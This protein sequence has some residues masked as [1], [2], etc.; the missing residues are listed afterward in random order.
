MNCL[1]FSQDFAIVAQSLEETSYNVDAAINY[2]LQLMCIAEEQ[3]F[4]GDHGLVF[5]SGTDTFDDN[6][7][8]SDTAVPESIVCQ[9]AGTNSET[10][11][12]ERTSSPENNGD[13]TTQ[14]STTDKTQQIMN[15]DQS[16]R[17]SLATQESLHEFVENL[18]DSL[19][20][21]ECPKGRAQNNQGAR[22]KVTR[23]KKGHGQ[24]NLS[25]KKRKELAKQ[26]KKKRKMEERKENG[27]KPS[28]SSVVTTENNMSG[29]LPDL[30]A[31]VI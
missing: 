13:N 26:E 10:V 24:G 15:F 20:R 25:N 5:N 29:V 11:N 16:E 18:R 21:P 27:P 7:L 6:S 3:G 17:E 23:P 4:T 30:G 12:E 14:N 22:P 9:E 1:F 8:T 19:T 31:L 28:T 2:V